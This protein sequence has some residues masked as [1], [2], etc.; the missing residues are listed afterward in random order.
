MSMIVRSARPLP[1]S[2]RFK[3]WHRSDTRSSL[4]RTARSEHV[5]DR[6]RGR[7]S[8]DD[9]RGSGD[10]EWIMACHARNR[11]A[12]GGFRTG[13]QTVAHGHQGH[14]GLTLWQER[15]VEAIVGHGPLVTC[16]WTS[17]PRPAAVPVVVRSSRRPR[18]A[19]ALAAHASSASRAMAVT[20]IRSGKAGNRVPRPV[21]VQVAD[22]MRLPDP[23]SHLR[24]AECRLK[25]IEIEGDR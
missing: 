2:D 17:W 23:P 6:Y 21:P 7:H 19:S 24:R 20:R 12:V 18:P 9:R 11:I 8:R 1:R 10:D 16:R 15:R 4:T 13:D 14:G 3:S 25:L 5:C 22:P